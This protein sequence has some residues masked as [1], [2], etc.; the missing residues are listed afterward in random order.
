[1]LLFDPHPGRALSLAP[2]KRITSG[3]APLIGKRDG[4]PIFALG[5]PGALRIP[6]ARCRRSS[7][8]SIT[9]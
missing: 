3:M 2:G 1:M 9:A 8:S 4:K 6:A 5:L 7:I